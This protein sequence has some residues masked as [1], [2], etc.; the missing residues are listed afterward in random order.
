MIAC[1][2]F[3]TVTNIGNGSMAASRTL[4][5][6]RTGSFRRRYEDGADHR[7]LGEDENAWAG[8]GH[9]ALARAPGTADEGHN[10]GKATDEGGFSTFKVVVRKV[11]GLGCS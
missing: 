7:T 10:Y 1:R 3:S 11:R 4:L 9:S 2:F 5:L 6:S 8:R